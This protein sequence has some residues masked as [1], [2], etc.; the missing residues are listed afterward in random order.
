MTETVVNVLRDVSS[1]ISAMDCECCETGAVPGVT[2]VVP[3]RVV[4]GHGIDM[5]REEEPSNQRPCFIQV[6]F[7]DISYPWCNLR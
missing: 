6:R 7:K 5:A 1:L 4:L 3:P 2:S